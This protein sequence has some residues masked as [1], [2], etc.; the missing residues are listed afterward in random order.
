ML[1]LY[2]ILKINGGQLEVGRSILRHGKVGRHVFEDR[3]AR[4]CHAGR[5]VD[6]DRE[7]FNSKYLKGRTCD[8]YWYFCDEHCRILK[9]SNLGG[10]EIVNFGYYVRGCDDV[11][12]VVYFANI[13]IGVMECVC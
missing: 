7:N 8:H 11:E 12:G 1:I 4:L 13:V 6:R 10:L 3:V 9:N 5:R 2:T